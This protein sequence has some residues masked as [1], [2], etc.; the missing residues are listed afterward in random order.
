MADLMYQVQ[1][2][3]EELRDRRAD[4]A[5]S[6]EELESIESR[7]DVIHRLRRKYAAS[8][9]GHSGLSRQGPEGAG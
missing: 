4:F 5:Y 6:G 9:Q 8:C 2:V 1:D 7:L 3:A